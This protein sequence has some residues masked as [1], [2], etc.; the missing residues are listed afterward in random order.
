M[1]RRPRLAS[2]PIL[3]LTAD[4]HKAVVASTRRSRAERRGLPAGSVPRSSTW[5][6]GRLQQ[7]EHRRARLYRR[8]ESA[9]CTTSATAVN[10]MAMVGNPVTPPAP[11]SRF[12]PRPEKRHS[13]VYGDHRRTLKARTSSLASATPPV[14]GSGRAPAPSTY[15]E[16][17]PRCAARDPPSRPVRHRVHHRAGQASGMLQT[18]VGK[19]TGGGLPCRHPTGRRA[20]DHAGRGPSV[21]SPGPSRTQLLFPHFDGRWAPTHGRIGAA[22]RHA[23]CRGREIAF[24]N[25]GATSPR[26]WP[27]G[28]PRASRETN[29]D[30]LRAWSR[31]SAS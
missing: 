23:R 30:D 21:E 12:Y 17:A 22:R 25:A 5:Y 31:R 8:R 4:D 20:P 10:V 11:A 19:R 9:S 3:S 27:R 13:G 15:A 24:D 28:H 2:R 14:Q 1:P 18:R 16:F 6:R 26:C 7:L 29:P